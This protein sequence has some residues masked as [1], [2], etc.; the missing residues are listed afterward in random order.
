M[1]AG[2]GFV[3]RTPLLVTLACVVGLWQ[4]CHHAA[5]VVQ[6]LFAT[7]KL[8]LSESQIGLSFV[9][10]GAGTVLAS[11]M[12]HRVSSRIGPGTCLLLG[13][14]L[15]ALGWLV[16]AAAPAN[17]WG[18]AAFA[19]MLFLFGVGAVLVFINFLS[20]RQAVTPT[21]LLGRMTSTIRWL[22]LLPAGP[23]ALIGGW[24]GEHV[25]LR[26]SLAFAGGVALLA[27]AVAWRWTMLRGVQELPQP[28]NADDVLGA[29]A[30]VS[31]LPAEASL[32]D[33]PVTRREA[34]DRVG[35]QAIQ[36]PLEQPARG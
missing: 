32:D 17:A 25:S 34:I 10:L 9:G 6:I 8:G 30:T 13:I 7:R 35:D 36:A 16:L 29:E 11:T 2:I 31:A 27:A 22:T 5:V 24:L 1:K 28:E 21:P 20:L 18:G 15:C 33:A 4:M 14:G 26:A 23:G 19:L 12:G 3:R